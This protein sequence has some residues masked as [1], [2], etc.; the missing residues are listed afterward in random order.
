MVAE[1]NYRLKS[2]MG[3]MKPKLFWKLVGQG[4]HYQYMFNA[5]QWN[6]GNQHFSEI[7][8]M[9]GVSSTD[10]SWSNLLADFDNDGWKDIYITNGLYRDIRNSDMAKIFPAYV[11]ETINNYLE[12]NPNAGEVHILDILNIEEGLDLHPSVPLNNYAYKNN[13][14]LTFT[15]VNEDWGVDLPSFSNGSAYGDLDNDGDLDMVVNNINAQAFLFENNSQLNKASNYLR[16]ELT[17]SINNSPLQGSH[18]EIQI[19]DKM[20]FIELSN[21][22]GMY[23][24]SENILHF[25]LGAAT[26]ID[27][28]K[29]TWPNGEHT[30]KKGINANQLLSIDYAEAKRLPSLN[31][32]TNAIFIEENLLQFGIDY[33]HQEN[34]F[35]DY[36]KQVLLPHEM[37][38]LGPAVCV[39]DINGD[40]KD[41]LYFG[42]A[43]GQTGSIY[44][45][46]DN[47]QFKEQFK[48]PKT[49]SIYEDV[50][51][52]FFDA[53]QDGDLD[54][55][56]VSGGNCFPPRSKNYLDRLYLN[57]GKGHFVKSENLPRIL[58]SGGCAKPFDYDNDGDLDLFIGGRHQPWDYP[59]PSISR[60]LKN[61][62]GV[63]EDVTKTSATALIHIGMVSDG[64]WTDFDQDG[65]TDLVIVGEWMP[66][67]FLKNMGAS[68][69]L[70]E[71]QI[72]QNDRTINTTGWYYAIQELDIDQDGDMD[73][74]L[75]NL[76]LNY[77]YKASQEE[78]FEVHYGDFD[79]NKKKDIVLSY[80]NFGEQFPLRGRSCSSAQT[81][82]IK[83]RFPSYTAFAGSNL[84]DVY[85]PV[86]LNKAL[87]I[88]AHQFASGILINHSGHFEF[89]PFPNE[90]QTSNINSIVI[91]DFNQDQKKD[92]FLAGNMFQSEI[93]TTR[94]DSGIGQL[95]LNVK[96]GNL[97]SVSTLKSGIVLSN[98][99]RSIQ[100]L[101][102]QN[103]KYLLVIINNEAPR[104]LKY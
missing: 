50:A 61:E 92:L 12:K 69:E 62:N 98:D 56:V 45:Q 99:V 57:D 84:E 28:M 37:S 7:A 16:V 91:E 4:A 100:K 90:T 38:K 59:S 3:S 97:T 82:E 52:S 87:N 48:F 88:K 73:Y 54:L 74:I 96:E 40:S 39:G 41:D 83:N 35:D 15:K 33:S 77:K 102:I 65:L 60:L 18:I 103:K 93:E 1:D 71:M 6:R 43:S 78:P 32:E 30:I 26:D 5:L 64:I 10:W 66:I 104:L 27:L 80:Y 101:T 36:S 49:D 67:K 75:G 17:D 95:L 25:G 42:G 81:P 24:C 9:A 2:N 21:A 63:F 31:I 86:A 11:K 29:I 13:G 76:G 23:S 8:Q 55:Y 19:D 44:I 94:N 22:R 58:E 72:K 68:F 89:E 46:L 34:A 85:S 51:A 79:G 14:D 47:G 53:D 20:Q 70:K